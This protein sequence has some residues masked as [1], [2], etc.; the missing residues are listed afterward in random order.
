MH[1]NFKKARSLFNSKWLGMKNTKMGMRMHG[2][3]SEILLILLVMKLWFKDIR[4]K[5]G[6]FYGTRN[7]HEWGQ[8]RSWTHGNTWSKL[9]GCINLYC[10]S[11]LMRQII[12]WGDSKNLKDKKGTPRGLETKVRLKKVRL[13]QLSKE[14]QQSKTN[15]MKRNKKDPHAKEKN[16]LGVIW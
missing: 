16:L 8:G 15:E 2:P 3:F 10:A 4:W 11:H 1:V 13:T 5:K 12:H 14:G 7:G 9:E 6:F